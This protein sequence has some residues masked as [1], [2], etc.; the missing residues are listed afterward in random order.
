MGSSLLA[1]TLALLA[2]QEPGAI[3]SGQVR[4]AGSG[5]PLAG[6]T[7]VLADLGLATT[8]DDAGRYL[9]RGVPAGT[10]AAAQAVNS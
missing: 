8:T 3:V 7:V 9:F 1:V 6:A 5:A 2:L 10:S 4:D